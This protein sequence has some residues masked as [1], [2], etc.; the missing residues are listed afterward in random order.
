M[1]AMLHDTNVM[2]CTVIGALH[3]WTHTHTHTHTHTIGGGRVGH[4]RAL[5]DE[6]FWTGSHDVTF[7]H[8]YYQLLMVYCNNNNDY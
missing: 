7:N 8:N 1:H 3:T 6:E 4:L 5:P 2:T